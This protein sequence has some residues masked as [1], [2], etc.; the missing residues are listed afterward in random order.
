MTPPTQL[1][2]TALLDSGEGFAALTEQGDEWLATG[3]EPG[4]SDNPHGENTHSTPALQKFH[5]P[6]A[7]PGDLIAIKQSDKR[8][9]FTRV[10]HFELLTPSADRVLPY[11]DVKGCGGCSWQS[12]SPAQ[13]FQHKI[14]RVTKAL[15]ERAHTAVHVQPVP[16]DFTAPDYRHRARL[17]AQGGRVGYEQSRSH[18]IIP[19]QKCPV[20]LPKMAVKVGYLAQ[21]L[22]KIPDFAGELELLYSPEED[23]LVAEVMT[24][25]AKQFDV[26]YEAMQKQMKAQLLA[27]VLIRSRPRGPNERSPQRVIG[28]PFVHLRHPAFHSDVWQAPR[29][30][31][32]P[33]VFSQA[34][35]QMNA[36]LI[37]RVKAAL[38]PGART[39]ELHAGAGNLTLA[40][41]QVCGEMIATEWDERAAM[42]L[43]RNVELH[44]LSAQVQV[45]TLSDVKT[46]AETDMSTI[47]CLVLDP[48]RTGA[49]EVF[50]ALAALPKIPATVLYVSCDPATLAR[51]YAAVRHRYL[52]G[53][54][55][56]FDMFPGTPHVETL[57]VLRAAK[58]PR[59]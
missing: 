4:E 48:P 13:A 34:N 5:I 55:H 38:P 52:I 40:I 54:V 23:R 10:S 42:C 30:Y 17:H 3:E 36:E 45:K 29:F 25:T 26:A 2:V 35:W 1:H 21:N 31:L 47:D 6:G 39:L 50:A 15:L 11:C 22:A 9:H 33:G 37:Q 59:V 19:F 49:A 12:F 24:Q 46:L 43:R 16:F 58:N 41:A 7:F 28:E 56:V 57:A 32:E 53:P 14:E 44:G 20:L 18:H 8:A 51:D 27:G